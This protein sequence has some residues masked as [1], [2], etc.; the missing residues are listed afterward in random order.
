[1][2][3]LCLLT[4]DRPCRRLVPVA[5]TLEKVLDSVTRL[6][7]SGNQ[8]TSC[9]RRENPVLV[10]ELD[11]VSKCFV[12]TCERGEV[13]ADVYEPLKTG[14]YLSIFLFE[15][16]VL[17]GSIV[18]AVSEAFI[19]FPAVLCEQDDIANGPAKAHSAEAKCVSKCERRAS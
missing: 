4:I 14:N 1:M 19:Y 13:G 8:R 18:A 7:Q 3:L 6:W 2:K 9:F 12:E 15:A 10:D 5:D 11:G 17:A 16:F